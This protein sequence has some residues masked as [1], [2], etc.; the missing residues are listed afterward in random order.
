[1]TDARK[2]ELFALS[3]CGWCR[4]TREWLDSHRVAYELTYLDQTSG[5]ELAAAKSRASRFSS[6]MSFPLV[7]VNDGEE[8]IPGYQPDRFEEVLG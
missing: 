7:V 3:T 8:V 2:V 5:D 4:K 1:M 6:R